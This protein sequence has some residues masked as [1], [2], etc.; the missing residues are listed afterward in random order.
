MEYQLNYR[1]K[2]NNLKKLK[3]CKI[4]STYLIENFLREDDE[5]MIQKF[6]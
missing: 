3:R 1:S 6:A 4:C 2:H 5:E